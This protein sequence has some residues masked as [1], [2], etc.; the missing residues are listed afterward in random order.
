MIRYYFGDLANRDSSL[1]FAELQIIAWI[2]DGGFILPLLY[3]LAL[4]AATLQEL[5]LVKSAADQRLRSWAAVVF[6]VQMGTIALV[7]GFIPFTSPVGLQYWFLAG[8]LQGALQKSGEQRS[9]VRE[10]K[11]EARSRKPASPVVLRS[12]TSD[13]SRLS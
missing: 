13:F 1:I 7:F 8:A 10:Q 3:G 2:L 9:E 11:P 4:L 12:L 6:A 5:R